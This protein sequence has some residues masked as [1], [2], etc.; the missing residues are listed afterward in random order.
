MEISQFCALSSA[1]VIP[2]DAPLG[3]CTYDK[4]KENVHLQLY[5]L[6]KSH[7]LVNELLS[8]SNVKLR[9]ET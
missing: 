9:L 4:R 6:S 3:L 1:S 5:V 2:W 8:V 7:S